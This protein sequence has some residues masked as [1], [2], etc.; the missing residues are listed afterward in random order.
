MATGRRPEV[1]YAHPNINQPT[2]LWRWATRVL[3]AADNDR[4][5]HLGRTTSSIF[6]EG[7][8]ATICRDDEAVPPPLAVDEEW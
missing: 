4:Y 6:S 5:T 3:C 2:P 1:L 7:S 8:V